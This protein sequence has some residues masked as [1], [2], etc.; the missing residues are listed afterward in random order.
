MLAAAAASRPTTS[1]LPPS[2]SVEFSAAA[3]VSAPSLP[4]QPPSL[5]SANSHPRGASHPLPSNRERA[6]FG[7]REKRVGSGGPTFGYAEDVAPP[8]ASAS[9]LQPRAYK[10]QKLN[11]SGSAPVA[12]SWPRAQHGHEHG[13]ERAPVVVGSGGGFRNLGNTC[14]MNAVLASLVGL[15]PFVSDVLALIS[16]FQPRLGSESVYSAL[17]SI[18]YQSSTESAPTTPRRLKDAIARRSAQFA[19]SA[20]QDAHEFLA[21]VLDGL[22]EEM[23]AAVGA[24]KAEL[25]EKEITPPLIAVPPWPKS[26]GGAVAGSG[27]PVGASSLLDLSEADL[28]CALNFTTEVEHELTCTSCGHC[29]AHIE[30]LRHFSLDLPQASA[31]H[32]VEPPDLEQLLQAFFAD[33]VVEVACERCDGTSAT[34][35]HSISKLPRVLTLHLKRFDATPTGVRKRLDP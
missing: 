10:Q 33:D 4:L 18:F 15:S 5:S 7:T 25:D 9:L 28:P 20:Q 24:A 6:L 11:V 17:Q 23:A 3:G 2:A 16:L 14:Y 27:G 19:G 13:H 8:L 29:W 32:P 26:G 21:D 12:P 34:V 35:T 1:E 31:S 30:I 22:Q